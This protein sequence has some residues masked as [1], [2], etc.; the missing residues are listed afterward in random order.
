MLLRTSLHEEHRS[1]GATLVDFAGWE[2]PLQYSSI[3]REHR[4]TRYGSGLFDVSHMGEILVTGPEARTLMERLIPTSLQ[5]IEPGR[6]MY[7]LLCNPSGGVID[8]LFVYML[9]P[10]RFFLVV[11]AATKEKDLEWI[12]STNRYSADVIDLTEETAKIDIQGPESGNI[13]N[14]ILENRLVPELPRFSFIYTPY[15]PDEIMVS[16][17][18][19]TGEYGFEVYLPS[20]SAV[21]LWRDLL[22]VGGERI[23]PAGLGARDTLRLEAGLS[24]YGHELNEERT[25]VESGLSWLVTSQSDY[26]GKEAIIKKKENGADYTIGAFRCTGKGVPRQ[27]DPVEV[28]GHPAGHVTSGGYSPTFEQGIGLALLGKEVQTGETMEIINRAR[29][30][31]AERCK[32][33]LYPYRGRD[34][35]DNV[36]NKES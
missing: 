15:G 19:Y 27:G 13:L 33:P 26:I 18:G 14:R 16:H 22:A 9:A 29:R 28:K 36:K 17:S 21:T 3:I 23:L 10:D 2:M 8:D 30:L 5:K 7:S 1:L 24:L 35:K 11:N 25:P 34:S 4:M 20:E 31:E 12:R 32:K 6:S